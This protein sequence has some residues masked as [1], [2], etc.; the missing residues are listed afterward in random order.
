MAERIVMVKTVTSVQFLGISG[1]QLAP[2]M[3]GGLDLK[4]TSKG[5]QVTS[6]QYEGK[7]FVIFN[8]N[9]SHVEYREGEE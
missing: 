3:G 1:T 7:R 4:E 6:K 8:A 2:T 5:I 9:I